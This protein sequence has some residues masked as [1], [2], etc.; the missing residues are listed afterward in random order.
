MLQLKH[1]IIAAQVGIAGST[2]IGDFVK[3]R[4]SRSFRHLKIGNNAT[5]AEKRSNKI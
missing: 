1:A 5:I 4:P 2:N 3:L